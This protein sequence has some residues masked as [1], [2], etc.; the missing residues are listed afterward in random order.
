M[1][2][3]SE[4]GRAWAGPRQVFHP[5][6]GADLLTL[7]KVAGRNGV[8]SRGLLA[9]AI[10][11]GAGLGRLPFTAAEALYGSWRGVA[12]GPSQA[13]VFILGHWRSGTTHLYNVMSKAPHWAFVS[14]FAT[15]LPWDFLLLAR[16][17][18][19]LLERALP[20]DRFID[21]IPVEPDSPQ[22]D[23]IGLA[24]MTDL[25]YYHA[26]YFPKRFQDIFEESLFF[27]NVSAERVAAWSRLLRY[28][29]GKLALGQGGRPL[30]I[31]N[32]VYTARVALLRRMWP[33]A[34]FIHIHRNPYKVYVSM[35]NFYERLFAEFALEPY[36]HVDVDAVVLDTYARMM[37]RYTEE[38][39]GLPSN[40][41]VE[42]R[43]D[44][45]QRE[46]MGELSK[47]YEQLGLAGFAEAEPHFRR[48]LA[49]VADYQKNSYAFPR[50]AAERVGQ[51]WA[52][53][54]ERWSYAPPA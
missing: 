15:A 18:G 33:D 45:F 42:L 11:F 34:K 49:S 40:Q 47:I 3:Q 35:R 6:C 43:F 52:P 19:P 23:E 8:G 4:S 28:Y 26:L 16:A 17:L 5:L 53:F 46:P 10:A 29:Y 7:S 9:L 25:S 44:D 14:P 39:E 20:K 54:I 1:K 27:T 30:L 37:T 38:S 22:E 50:E 31:K 41:L 32:P 21:N 36:A 13:P 48:Y 24:N 12:K 2:G 51:H